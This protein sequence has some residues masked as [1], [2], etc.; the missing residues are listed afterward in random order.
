MK[1]YIVCW[2]SASQDDD[3]NARAYSGVHGVYTDF[4]KAKQSLL[5]CKNETYDE[6]VNDPDFDEEVREEIKSTISVYG[7]VD[8]GYFE[9]DYVMGISP[10]E[11]YISLVEKELTDSEN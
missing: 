6:L 2:G 9:I 11:T 8:E 3:G 5:D 10:C 1:L 7:S 4:A